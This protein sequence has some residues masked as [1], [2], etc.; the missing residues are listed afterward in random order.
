MNPNPL[1]AVAQL[2]Q[3]IWVDDIGRDMLDDGR[4]A[5]M[6]SDDAVTGLTSNPAIFAQSMMKDAAYRQAVTKLGAA[7]KT[8]TAVYESLALEDLKR[9]ADLLLPVYERQNRFDGFVSME[10]S[11]HLAHDTAGTVEEGKRLW[12]QLDRPNAMI[13]VPGTQAG[14]GAIRT[15]IAAGVNVNVTLLFAPERY[16]E[17]A[18]AYMAGLEARVAKGE[19]I[20]GIASVASFFLSR[21]DTNVDARIDKLVQNGRA[22]AREL[23]GKA[24][25]AEARAAYLIFEQ[26]TASARWKALEEQGARVQRLLWASTSAK[27][28]AY[29]PVKYVD[30]LIAPSTVNTMPLATLEAYRSQGKP[31][32]SLAHGEK[33][34]YLREALAKFDIDLDAVSRE[35]EADGVK[36]FIEP[37]DR[38]LGW[39][40]EQGLRG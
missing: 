20:D 21:I 4:L 39:L 23:R 32:L 16:R 19:R 12:A 22:E 35:L 36:K 9:A 27:D 10:V 11:P 40:A 6:I 1:H 34:T 26:L 30:E 7:G 2:G 29:S 31:T 15:L 37:F 25:I 28:K 14:L 38:I 18:E 24:A 13:K 3:S 8:G 5:R 33:D 17:V